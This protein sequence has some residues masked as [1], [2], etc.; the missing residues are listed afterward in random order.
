MTIVYFKHLYKLPNVILKAYYDEAYIITEPTKENYILITD[1]FNAPDQ[2]H[3]NINGIY[4]YIQKPR[5]Q[6]VIN[7]LGHSIYKQ[8]EGTKLA[9]KLFINCTLTILT[10]TKF[11]SR[12]G[13]PE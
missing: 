5:L 3:K 9:P 11:K 10:I 7:T 12:K 13:Q 2:Y 6:I 1:L 8:L 4:V